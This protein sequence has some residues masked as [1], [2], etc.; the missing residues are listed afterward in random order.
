MDWINYLD[1]E[2]VGVEVSF[3]KI[4]LIPKMLKI[5]MKGEHWLPWKQQLFTK[6]SVDLK[7]AI[8]WKLGNGLS[9]LHRWSWQA[10]C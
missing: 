8:L 9:K 3:Y 10:S 6:K 2:E 5:I 4:E 1:F 7:S